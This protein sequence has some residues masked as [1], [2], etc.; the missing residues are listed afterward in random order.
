M[1][2]RQRARITYHSLSRELPVTFR[3][4]HSVSCFS[5]I[6][7]SMK[8]WMICM[9]WPVPFHNNLSPSWHYSLFIVLTFSTVPIHMFS[10]TYILQLI[11][12]GYLISLFHY[13]A[14]KILVPWQLLVLLKNI[15]NRSSTIH[16]SSMHS[17]SHHVAIIHQ[18]FNE[19]WLFYNHSV[20]LLCLSILSLL[21]LKNLPM[22]AFSTFF[23][24][25]LR[26]L[27]VTCWKETCCWADIIVV[28]CDAMY[29]WM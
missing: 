2:I 21:P 26:S 6:G 16:P 15:F 3:G 11:T 27:F 20:L 29:T 14:T 9:I 18:C 22:L 10:N 5:G 8:F 1:W 25:Y 28:A 17:T 4:Q 24:I 13:P 19:V 7:Y 12:A 23:L